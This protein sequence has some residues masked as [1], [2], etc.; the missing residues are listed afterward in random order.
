MN[1]VVWSPKQ[2]VEPWDNSQR[3][4]DQ[5]AEPWDNSHSSVIQKVKIVM[6]DHCLPEQARQNLEVRSQSCE[7]HRLQSSFNQ[8][9]AK[10]RR[11]PVLLTF[12]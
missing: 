5:K 2:K 4:T 7:L 9:L 3:I 11:M 10:C 12:A 8:K 6:I 1:S